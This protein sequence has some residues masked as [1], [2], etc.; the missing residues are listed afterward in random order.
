[1][2]FRLGLTG[3]IGTGKST[4]AALFR[5]HGVPV[6]D[7]DATVHSLYAGEAAPLIEAVF[8]GVVVDGVVDRERLAARVIGNEVAMR[9]LE[10]IVHP[11]VR[12]R[13][14][15]FL[16][17]ARQRGAPLAVLDIPLLFETGGEARCDAVVVVSCAQDVQRNR[18]MSRPGMTQDRFGAILARQV[19]DA[20]KRARA[21]WVINSGRGFE[22]AAVQVADLLR[23]L[24]GRSRGLHALPDGAA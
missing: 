12:R 15:V 7:A 19:P 22:A 6:H 2:V 11:L 14:Q 18:V 1:M 3:S 10:S 20:E 5:E 9:R 23:A 13:E 8:T 4:T 24:A 16:A 17:A 21:H